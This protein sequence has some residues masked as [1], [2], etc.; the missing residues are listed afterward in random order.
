MMARMDRDRDVAAF[1]RRASSYERGA[2]GRWHVEVSRRVAAI[3][4]DELPQPTVV[5]DVGCGTGA[6]L[7]ELAGRQPQPL[8]RVGIDAA[9][10]MASVAGL[11]A[12]VAVG[13]AERLPF[14]DGVFDLV[15]S[16]LSFDHWSDQRQGLTEC[17]RVL[18]PS[19]RLLLV[20]LFSP[21]LWPT[22]RLGRRGRTRTV[23]GGTRLLR[24]AGFS[25]VGWRRVA[26]LVRAAV[27]T[28]R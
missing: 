1:D 18:A 6:L 3:I 5:L 26:P 24:Q 22:T 10:A 19:G 28:R 2:I 20:D 11:V 14:R 21:W 13:R 16:T 25:D 9:P 12:P 15:L 27:A 8:R 23:A 7:R 17:G 4:R